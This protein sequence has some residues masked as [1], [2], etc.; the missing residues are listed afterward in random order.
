M[1][2]VLLYPLYRDSRPEQ[3]KL[4]LEAL[5]ESYDHHERV[6][7]SNLTIEH[8]MPQTLTPEWEAELGQSAA[9]THKEWMHRLA[10]LT[11]SGY[12]PSLS[13]LSFERKREIFEKSH[14]ELNKEVAKVER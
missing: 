4:I 2:G 1:A 5:E 10:N 3:R 7:F 13:N 6:D 9:E 12:N 11:L 14:L 8:I